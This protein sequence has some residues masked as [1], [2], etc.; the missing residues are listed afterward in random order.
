VLARTS[1]ATT[2]NTI[3]EKKVRLEKN[4]LSMQ[5]N[6]PAG[7]AGGICF[8]MIFKDYFELIP[9]RCFSGH[10][11]AALRPSHLTLIAGYRV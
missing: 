4:N 1:Y 9:I 5:K 7:T 11:L 3:L 6:L 10:L 8:V 2:G